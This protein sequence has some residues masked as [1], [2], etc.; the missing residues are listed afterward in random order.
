MSKKIVKLKERREQKIKETRSL[1]RKKFALVIS[2]VSIIV[3]AGW[4][5][6]NSDFFLVKEIKVTGNKNI[7]DQKLIENS[8]IERSDNL[9]TLPSSDISK[10]LKKLSWVQHAAILKDWPDIVILDVIERKPLA[11]IKTE[12]GSYLI[13]KKAFAVDKYRQKAKDKLPAIN[14]LESAK[15]NVGVYLKNDALDNALK[16]YRNLDSDIQKDISS[17][18]AATVDDFYF[19]SGG[20]EIVYGKAEAFEM[21][22]A[23]IKAIFKE[24]KDSISTLDVRIPN[25]PVIRVLGK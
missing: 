12:N 14:G 25:K 23:V 10:R 15:I 22:N 17:M 19:V 18:G 3:L 24:R 21:K 20:V 5:I 7:S 16:A 8:G 6:Y 11:Y 1:R 13:D 2:S 9:L 4:L